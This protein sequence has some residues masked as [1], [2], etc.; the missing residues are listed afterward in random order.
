MNLDND[1][2]LGIQ[3]NE[4][5]SFTHAVRGVQCFQAESKFLFRPKYRG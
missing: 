2:W 3:Q 4:Q 5:L 1:G